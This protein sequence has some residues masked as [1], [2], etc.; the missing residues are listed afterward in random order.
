[1]QE[2]TVTFLPQNKTVKVEKG[3]NLL[4]A[5]SAANITINN[6]CGGDGI[7]GR[8]KML[9]KKGELPEELSGKLT[10]HDIQ[11][12]YV[13]ACL[14]FVQNDMI[15]EIPEETWAKEKILRNKKITG[16]R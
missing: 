10:R 11:M 4:E 15:V 9:I 5:A 6:V 1:M 7:C 2:C 3:T 13:L 12:G 8:C 14:T 16:R